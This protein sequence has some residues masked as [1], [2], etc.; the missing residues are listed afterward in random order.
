MG[1]HAGRALGY[2]PQDDAERHAAE[3]EAVPETDDDRAEAAHVGGRYA[4][5][6]F[7]QPAFPDRA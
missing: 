7:E 5:S 3:I 1:P 2:D 6:R 4:T